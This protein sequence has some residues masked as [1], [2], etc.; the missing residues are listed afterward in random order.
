MKI[1]RLNNSD[2]VKYE[3]LAIKYG[4]VFNTFAWLKLFGDKVQIYGIYD[5]GNNLVTV[6]ID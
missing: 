1:A 2:K 4:T 5:E 6:R 3:E